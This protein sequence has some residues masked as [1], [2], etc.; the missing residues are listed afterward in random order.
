MF[1]DKEFLIR[2]FSSIFIVGILLSFIYLFNPTTSTIFILTLSIL[3]AFEWNEITRTAN[4]KKWYLIGLI[5]ILLTFMPILFIKNNFNKHYIMW[6]FILIWSVDTFAY[7]VGAKLKLGKHKITKISP[8]KS[9]EGLVGG[10][11]G[12]TICCF[13]FASIFLEHDKYLLLSITPILAIL[14]QAS[15]IMESYIKRKFNLKDSGN[16]IPGHGGIVDR[17]DGFLLTGVALSLLL[18]TITK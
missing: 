9:Y 2:S 1:K 10:I 17:F 7:L 4:N 16:L 6:L 15:D 18:I 14:E 12:S 8:N 5:Y 11:I 13:I 3:S